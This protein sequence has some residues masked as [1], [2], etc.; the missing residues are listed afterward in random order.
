MSSYAQDLTIFCGIGIPL[1]FICIEDFLHRAILFGDLGRRGEFFFAR[2]LLSQDVET[3][4]SMLGVFVR[5][6]IW[7][8]GSMVKKKNH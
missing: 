6:P 2:C 3:H 4:V 1:S 7:S 8:C 5:L